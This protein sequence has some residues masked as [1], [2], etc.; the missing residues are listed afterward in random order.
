[1]AL[2]WRKKTENQKIKGTLLSLIK[3]EKA[4]CLQ[5]FGC[6]SSGD[7]QNII[8][9]K[10]KLRL[11]NITSMSKDKYCN[12]IFKDNFKTFYPDLGAWH[13]YI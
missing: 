5:I 11:V 13:I 1:M 9:C 2:S 10:I 12:T 3:L 6:F 7:G 4:I 8:F